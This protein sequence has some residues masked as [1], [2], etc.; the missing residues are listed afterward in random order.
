M[1]WTGNEVR[2]GLYINFV[3][4]AAA[5]IK[6]G[7]RG[8]VAIPLVSYGTNATAKTFYTVET[9]QEA[10][11]L[12]G[13]TNIQSIKFALQGGAKEVLVYCLPTID[14]TTVTESS[15]YSEARNSFEAYNFNVFVYDENVSSTEQDAGLAWTQTNRNEGKHFM[16]V[17]GGSST[18]DQDPSVG[19][20]RSVRLA[21]DYAVNLI[22]GV[23]VGGTEYASIDY[24]PYIAGLIAG[25]R[26]NA[27]VT[28]NIVPVDDVNKRLRNSEIKTSLTKG[29]LVLVNDGE[30][31]RVEQGLTTS[32]DKIR[33]VRARQ[34]ISMDITKTARD[35]YIGRIDNSD[36]GRAALMSSI[37]AYMEKL[38]VDNVLANPLVELDDQR[39]ST[40]DTVYLKVGMTEIDSMEK[41]YL[42]IN[43]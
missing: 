39:D 23:D 28:Y 16:I 24:S 27:S 32:I 5:Q 13:S 26:I 12:F 7:S 8:T 4:A 1:A 11:D 25:T 19:D 22:V 31:I 35:S 38:A 10:I 42:T 33:S 34:A 36:D 43:I 9:E 40:G 37:K 30:K 14:G 41:I 17:F 15:A 6:G 29:S 18:D 2:P 20:A 3:E 21:D